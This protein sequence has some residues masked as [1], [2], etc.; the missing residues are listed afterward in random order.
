MKRKKITIDMQLLR[1]HMIRFCK[2]HKIA[3]LAMQAN[4]TDSC[5]SYHIQG[6]RN[7]KLNI[8]QAYA[9]AMDKRMDTYLLGSFENQLSRA[10]EEK[11]GFLVQ[12]RPS[13]TIPQHNTAEVYR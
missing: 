13:S 3:W 7:P 1:S 5:V 8:I 10:A 6:G 11:Q 4:V 2:K 12:M 9:M